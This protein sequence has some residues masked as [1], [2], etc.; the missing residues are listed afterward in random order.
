[1]KKLE[2]RKILLGITGGIA[3]YK[4]AELTRLLKKSGADV[5]VVMTRA[6]TAFVGPL[7]FQA[8]SGRPVS[9]E[10]LDAEAEASMGHI[11]LSRWADLILIAPASADFIAKLRAGVADDLLSTLCL[12]AAAPIAVAPAMN[13]KMWKHPATQ[14]NVALLVER[15][16]AVW[17]P[18][19]GE[20]ACGETG[21]GR[22]LEPETLFKKVEDY[23]SSGPLKGV[24][25][26][27]NAGPTQEPIDPVRYITNRSTGKMGYEIARAAK[28]A[29]ARVC[30]VS[31][32]SSE[33][34]PQVDEL[35][36]VT[37]AEE[38][39]GAVLERASGVD[40]FIGAAAVADYRPRIVDEKKIKK[41]NDSL[42][43]ELEKT[44]D[45]LATVSSMEDR[46]Y[47]VGFAAETHDLENYA[48]GK[49]RA[50]KLDMIAANHV[51]GEE[52]GFESEQNALQLFWDGGGES[53]GM[54][55]KSALAR[56]LIKVIT[57]KF[58]EKSR[59]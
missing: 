8:L 6:A 9:T 7:T 4:C 40:I 29:G 19:E 22:M 20:Q 44:V 25:V 57:E 59:V 1:M 11:H 35:V 13:Q 17:G 49:L 39:A 55:D 32:P 51:G 43:I 23:F 27:V 47:C 3:A 45:I 42:T 36:S 48:L 12:A 15:E 33:N 28:S 14:E 53:L 54:V 2:G 21:P 26:L 50:K 31:G 30:L 46:P 18:A 41:T 34:V 52:G 16:V 5:R 58:N 10:L 38:M 37:T 24:S 56:Q